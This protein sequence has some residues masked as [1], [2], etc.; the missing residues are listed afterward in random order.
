LAFFDVTTKKVIVPIAVD[1]D[2]TAADAWTE[3]VKQPLHIVKVEFVM[4]EATDGAVAT[5]AVLSVDVINA[6]N[7]SRTELLT[8]T[9]PDTAPVGT[10]L[11]LVDSNSQ[12]PSIILREDDTI[13]FEHKTASTGSEDGAGYFVYYYELIGDVTLT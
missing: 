4:T 3:I 2:A 9:V 6:D 5:D 10:T 13:Y 7:A 11:E 12:F 1:L 8:V